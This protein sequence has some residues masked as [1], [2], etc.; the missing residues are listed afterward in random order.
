MQA[1][2]DLA[3]EKGVG[4]TT[5]SAIGERAGYSRGLASQH[6]GSKAGLIEAVIEN[7][8][9]EMENAVRS[10]VEDETRAGLAA[11]DEY[12]AAYFSSMQGANAYRAYFTFLSG[13]VA[14]RSDLLGLFAASHERVKEG[15]ADLIDQGRRDGT[16]ET[17]SNPE[18]GALMLGSM[19]MGVSIQSLIDPAFDLGEMERQARAMVSARFAA[20][21]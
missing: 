20:R 13:A 2:L 14:E 4:A 6:F 8:H 5:F 15:I 12:I 21:A 18:A 16:I 7:L 9:A 19:L 11:L 3:K 10:I 1:A 17:S